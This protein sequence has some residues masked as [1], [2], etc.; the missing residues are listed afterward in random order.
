MS[1]SLAGAELPH[2]PRSPPPRH[3]STFESCALKHQLQTARVNSCVL[4]LRGL[5][6]RPG[7]V[8]VRDRG[9]L[10]LGLLRGFGGAEHQ[11]PFPQPFPQIQPADGALV[12]SLTHTKVA[13]I[14]V[15]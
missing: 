6:N 1:R 10:W 4:S 9:W 2:S 11:Q 3:A 8:P 15:I 5:H 14:V 7:V 12:T 13:H